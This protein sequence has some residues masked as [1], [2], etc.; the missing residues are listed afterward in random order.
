MSSYAKRSFTRS[1]SAATWPSA[2]RSLSACS[3]ATAFSASSLGAATC[4]SAAAI[5]WSF[6]ALKAFS[7]SASA[8]KVVWSAILTVCRQFAILC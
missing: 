7:W 2:T 1:Y 3:I 5:A 6:S 8:D 4:S